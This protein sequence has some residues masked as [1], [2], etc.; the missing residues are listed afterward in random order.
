MEIV[1]LRVQV[2]DSQLKKLQ[3]DVQALKGTTINLGAGGGGKGSD[4]T[5]GTRAGL[6]ATEQQ[7]TKTGQSILSVMGKVAKWTAVTTAVYAPIKAFKEAVTTIKALDT[8]MVNIQKVTGATANQM[9]QYQEQAYSL[10]SQ[11]GRSAMDVAESMTAFARAGYGD[12][13]AQMSE[14]STLMQNVG[15]VSADTANSMLLAVDAAWHLNGSQSELMKVMDGVDKITNQNATDFGKMAEGMTVAASVFA[16]SGESIQTFASMV[17]TGTAV[18]QRSGSE[19]ARG[20]RTVLM[21]IRQIKGETEDGELI[22]GES[23]AKAS[24]A[25]KEFAGINTMENGELR[26]ASD[27][28]GDL[29]AKWENLDSVQQSAI[30]EALAG[31]RQANIL[32][33]LMGNWDMYEKQMEEYATAAGTALKENEI[34][35]DSWAAKS[36]QLKSKWTEFVSGF[37]NTG[38]IKGALDGLIGTLNFLDSG[39]GESVVQIGLLTA[40]ISG[41]G[42][43]GSALKAAFIGGA[44]GKELPLIFAGLA[45]GAVTAGQAIKALGASLL[46]NPLFMAA[47]AA[48][49]T[50]GFIKAVDAATVTLEEQEAT[51]AEL[52]SQY[53]Q[54]YGAGSE[55]AGLQSRIE[56]G[57]QLNAL[58]ERR[59]AILQSQADAMQQ[60]IDNESR[61]AFNLF[62]QQDT[63]GKASRRDR[64]GN[65]VYSGET[66]DA[67]RLKSMNSALEENARQYKAGQ[68]SLEE[69]RSSLLDLISDNQ[70]W[71]DQMQQWEDLGFGDS[72]T[73][74]QREAKALYES[75]AQLLSL[76]DE[77]FK[78]VSALDDFQRAG[79][80]FTEYSGEMV[81]NAEKLRKNLSDLGFSAEEAQAAIDGLRSDGVIVID[82]ENDGVDTTLSQLEDLGIAVKDADGWEINID[83]LDS[84]AS[85]LGLSADQA[86]AL[87]VALDSVDG[88]SLVDAQGNAVS[89]LD[90][91]TELGMKSPVELLVSANTAQADS[92]LAS[93]EGKAEEVDNSDPNVNVTA[94]DN[95]SGTISVP[96][97]KA[98]MFGDMSPSPTLTAKDNASGVINGAVS[99]LGRFVSKTITITARYITSGT[100]PGGGGAGSGTAGVH[101]ATG[102]INFRGGPVL[103]GDEYSPTGAP[104]PE[105]VITRDGKAFLAG[106][107]G[108]VATTLPPGSRIFKYSD[109]LDVF[110]GQDMTAIAAYAG[111]SGLGGMTLGQRY[112]RGGSSGGSGASSS[113]SSSSG[114]SKSGGSG[115]KSKSGSAG[116]KSGGGS[117]SSGRKSGGGSSGSSG[118]SSSSGSGTDATLDNLK[119]ELELLQAQYSLLEAQ[120][121]TTGEL[122]SKS[123]EIQAKLH[124]INDHL[125]ATGGEQKDIVDNSTA[126]VQEQTK[127]ISLREDD[128][129]LLRAEYELLEA[130]GADTETLRAKS[131]EIQNQLHVIN[132]LLRKTGGSQKDITQNSTAWLDEQK[133]IQNVQIDV[134]EANRHLLET[135]FEIMEK[136]N[137]SAGDRIAKLRKIQD[138][139]HREA[140]YM[141]SIKGDQAGINELSIKWLDVQQQ[142]LRIQQDLMDELDAA[143]NYKLKLARKERDAEL[144]LIDKQIE[145][146]EKERDIQEDQ[147]SIEEKRKAVEEARIALENA[148]RQRTVRYYNAATGQWE[149]AADAKNVASA[150]K[151]YEQALKDFE[152]D[153][154]DREHDL[155]IQALELQ[156]EEINSRYDLLEARWEALTDSFAD[157]I[158]DIKDILADLL[159]SGKLTAEQVAMVKNL[160]GDIDKYTLSIL[161]ALLTFK[162]YKGIIPEATGN[163]YGAYVIDW[164]NKNGWTEENLSLAQ[165]QIQTSGVASAAALLAAEQ[166]ARAKGT[167]TIGANSSGSAPAGSAAAAAQAAVSQAVSSKS[168]SSS[169]SSKSSSSS[170]SSKSSLSNSLVS[171]AA[172]KVGVSTATAQKAINSVLNKKYDSGGVLSGLGGIKA[173]AEDEIVVPP[174]IARFMLKPSAN[175]QFKQRMAEL[176]YLYGSGSLS[177][178]NII[179]GTQNGSSRNHYGDIYNYGSI[180]LSEN[181]ARNMTVYELAQK[182]RG[183]S[184]YSAS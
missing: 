69:Y 45:D 1:E 82:V 107:A 129:A 55:L 112:L 7:A 54:L 71:Y 142:I 91:M 164:L 139:L 147:L 9:K 81:V 67:E 126:W 20:L 24:L 60:Q 179:G 163:E 174:E 94:T 6:K 172:S 154:K 25:L 64:E 135:E 14:L 41:L 12:Q 156:K 125:R 38:V 50:V 78:I 15:Y 35:M 111:G 37:V 48:A 104:R 173:T 162:E 176:G 89:L 138:N 168:G 43:A 127:Q 51:V 16:E 79:V 59:L 47:G 87:A 46:A 109:T 11:Y 96:T 175:Q 121:A 80:G 118:S 97:A 136:Q 93:V 166:A 56:A 181:Q 92:G 183:L 148:Q 101:K 86:D 119:K 123:Q 108:P 157:P 153:K 149:W 143:V 23:I 103:L 145:G 98:R 44:F 18:T 95:A 106:T 115:S 53:E 120:N 158:R 3:A 140:E 10:A 105:L 39:V 184:V 75:I 68:K 21:N 77:D 141:R 85:E 61:F 17:G 146:L 114:S 33:A 62:Q 5:S 159:A 88:V 58:E 165:Q 13:L 31:K 150:R 167:T 83:S 110:S 144:K 151:T 177:S 63:S 57:E 84:L 42:K 36:E 52:K 116:S 113:S 134:Y 30:A 155:R 74:A 180:T 182:S 34:Y 26:K 102:D 169:S 8:E 32:T 28:L 72:F 99:A 29:A 19:I 117:K 73:D 131:K 124:Q 171:N 100:G 4:P 170:S 130:S 132:E 161:S 22:D 27:I 128:L 40:G 160:V 178:A 133:K 49:V 137:A 76:G 2:E 70:E 66:K 65:M 152:T 90:T 122:S